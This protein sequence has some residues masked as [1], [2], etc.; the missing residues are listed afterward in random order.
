VLL[1]FDPGARAARRG[2]GRFICKPAHS[3][4]GGG[5]RQHRVGV[6]VREHSATLLTD[7]PTP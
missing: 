7:S 5:F 1:R 2:A 4:W 3:G 6:I